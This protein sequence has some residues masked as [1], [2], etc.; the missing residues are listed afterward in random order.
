MDVMDAAKLTRTREELGV[1]GLTPGRDLAV[2]QRAGEDQTLLPE[3]A[4]PMAMPPVLPK[5]AVGTAIGE[6]SNKAPAWG[7][8]ART[9][10]PEVSTPGGANGATQQVAQE[11]GAPPQALFGHEPTPAEAAQA[12]AATKKATAR[13]LQTALDE[14]EPKVAAAAREESA[15]PAEV[16]PKVKLG[17]H[18]AAETNGGV[19]EDPWLSKVNPPDSTRQGHGRAAPTDIR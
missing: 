2:R 13:S 9:P 11:G 3:V 5:G 18:K 4:A 15:T 14:K 19:K 8:Q 12:A 10:N 7:A 16:A 6:A 1:S 17:A